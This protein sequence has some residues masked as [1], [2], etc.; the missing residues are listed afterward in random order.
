MKIYKIKISIKV[1][2]RTIDLMRMPKRWRRSII[3]WW[4]KKQ[5]DKHFKKLN[6]GDKE[7]YKLTMYCG[8]LKEAI[9]TLSRELIKSFGLDPYSYLDSRLR[10]HATHLVDGGF[11]VGWD[12]HKKW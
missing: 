4:Q 8:S 11:T 12:N 2:H 9:H 1:T 6:W 5:L 10:D 7:V 3:V